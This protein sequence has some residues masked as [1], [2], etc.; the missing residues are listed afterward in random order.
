MNHLGEQPEVVPARL[1]MGG[2]R[3]EVA[4]EQQ[5]LVAAALGQAVVAALPFE[6]TPGQVLAALAVDEATGIV[7]VLE[8]RPG[9]AAG[10]AFQRQARFLEVV[11]AAGD[12]AGA[13]FQA[14]TE[15][16]DRRPVGDQAGVLLVGHRREPRE[17]RLVVA[18]YQQVRR[19]AVLEMKV[20]ALLA[21]QALDELQV[22]LVVLHAVFA[23]G[24]A[25]AELEAVGVGEDAVFL[26][27]PADD[28]RHREVL[29]DAL[30]GAL[31]EV[32]Q[33]R[34]EGDAV[35]GQALARVALS[36]AAHQ[37]VDTVAGGPEGKEGGFVQQ[38]FEVR[39][40][41]FADQ[42]QVEGE[43]LADGF[44]AAEGKHL[45]VEGE[46]VDGEAEVGLVGCCEHPLSL[47]GAGDRFDCPAWRGRDKGAQ[48]RS[49]AAYNKQS[50]I[51]PARAFLA[52][53]L[54]VI[55]GTTASEAG[56]VRRS[57]LSR[58]PGSASRRSRR[59]RR[60]RGSR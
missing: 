26:Q 35:A 49:E 5:R 31:G 17:H 30:V 1:G 42:L 24:V 56:R 16:L 36:G 40:G 39:H 10:G 47:T 29:E 55:E 2:Q 38:A 14:Y 18:E 59:C 27:H 57:R 23:L 9:F 15:A 33:L 60:L 34:D 4:A 41:A 28:L 54:W 13:G 19:G 46:A 53:A 45:Q 11:V 44:A 51:D 7:V 58:R 48:A 52:T 3:Q 6:G 22:A 43:R 32:G 12:A 37:A 20:D 8:V 25:G 21:A 50:G